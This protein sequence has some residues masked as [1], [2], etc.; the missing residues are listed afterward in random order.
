MMSKQRGRMALPYSKVCPHARGRV[1]ATVLSM[2]VRVL[3]TPT[4]WGHILIQPNNCGLGQALGCSFFNCKMTKKEK[5]IMYLPLRFI[6]R[7]NEMIY[8][9]RLAQSLA[10]RTCALNSRCYH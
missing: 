9:V 6:V 3:C 7:V 2:E 4:T 10:H 1:D 5:K 8:V